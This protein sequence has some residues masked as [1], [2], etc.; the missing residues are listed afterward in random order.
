MI[1]SKVQDRLFKFTGGHI[2]F[3]TDLLRLIDQMAF[4][5]D[6]LSFITSQDYFNSLAILRG[7]PNLSNTSDYQKKFLRKIVLSGTREPLPSTEP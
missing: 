3:L 4:P 6:L 1:E 7:I 5:N 2:G